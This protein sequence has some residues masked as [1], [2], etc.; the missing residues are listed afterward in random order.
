MAGILPEKVRLRPRPT[1][2]SPLFQR[3]LYERAAAPAT[4]LLS[5]PQAAWRRYVRADCLAGYLS[6]DAPPG[7]D[8]PEQVVLWRCICYELWLRHL[9]RV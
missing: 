3:G 9:N 8:G 1:W 6:G 4:A 7:P 5:A 2:V